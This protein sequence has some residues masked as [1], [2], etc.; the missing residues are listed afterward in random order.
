MKAGRNKTI[1]ISVEE[2]RE[3]LQKCMV[4]EK[5]AEISEILDKTIIGNTMDVL[6]FLPENSVDLLIVDPPY[7][8][9]KDFNGNKFKKTS[10]EVYE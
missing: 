10:D 4:L 9:D 7:N 2:G 6:R 3:Y 1:D 5:S 8:L